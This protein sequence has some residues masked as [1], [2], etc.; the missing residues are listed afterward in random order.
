MHIM[1]CEACRE[2][3]IAKTNKSKFPYLR[4]SQKKQYGGSGTRDSESS[5]TSLLSTKGDLVREGL[6]VTGVEGKRKVTKVETNK[7][8]KDVLGK[9]ENQRSNGSS[10]ESVSTEIRRGEHDVPIGYDSG[11]DEKKSTVEIKRELSIGDRGHEESSEEFGDHIT[12]EEIDSM[13]Q[14]DIETE[15]ETENEK[16]IEKATNSGMGDNTAQKRERIGEEVPYNFKTPT[17]TSKTTEGTPGGTQGSLSRRKSL[18]I[19]LLTRLQEMQAAYDE[20]SIQNHNLT[21]ILEQERNKKLEVSEAK[22]EKKP[23]IDLRREKRVASEFEAF[24]KDYFKVILNLKSPRHEGDS[25]KNSMATP[26]K[27]KGNNNSAYSKNTDEDVLGLDLFSVNVTPKSNNGFKGRELDSLSSRRDK[28]NRR[29]TSPHTTTLLRF[30]DENGDVGLDVHEKTDWKHFEMMSMLIKATEMGRDLIEKVEKFDLALIDRGIETNDKA[31]ELQTLLLEKDVE[32]K[33]Y[34]RAAEQLE[35]MDEQ[36]YNLQS[37]NDALQAKVKLLE[38]TLKRTEV[39]V[40]KKS[41][42][43]VQA[44]EKVDALKATEAEL[45]KKY[46]NNQTAYERDIE[47]LRSEINTSSIQHSDKVREMAQEIQTLKLKLEQDQTKQ[48]HRKGRETGQSTRGFA[49]VS[50]TDISVLEKTQQHMEADNLQKETQEKLQKMTEVY[51]Q[52]KNYSS[53]LQRLLKVAQNRLEEIKVMHPELEVGVGLDA[54]GQ[55]IKQGGG[56]IEDEAN[57]MAGY[58]NIPNLRSPSLQ[59]DELVKAYRN[60]RILSQA[61]KKPSYGSSP[62]KSSRRRPSNNDRHSS[63]SESETGSSEDSDDRY[64]KSYKQKMQR[65]RRGQDSNN[66][67]FRTPLMGSS[68]DATFDRKEANS[69]RDD[70]QYTDGFS[71]L[72]SELQNAALP[73]KNENGEFK[74]SNSVGVQATDDRNDSDTQIDL[75]LE[76]QD[77]CLKDQEPELE[78]GVAK[79]NL[80][81]RSL[82]EHLDKATSD[83]C[84]QT[85]TTDFYTDA[86]KEVHVQVDKMEAG[87]NTTEVCT[88]TE[89]QPEN[90]EMSIQTEILIQLDELAVQTESLRDIGCLNEAHTQTDFVEFVN[91]MMQTETLSEIG[92]TTEVFIQT[93]SVTEMSESS[94]QTETLSE[95]GY[96]EDIFTQTDQPLEPKNMSM[97]TETLSEIGYTEDIFTQTEFITEISESS[98][99]TDQPLEPKSISIQTETLSEIGYIT[100]VFTQTDQ[101]IEPKSMSIQ[102]ETLSEIGY[103]EDTFTQTDQPLEPNNMSMQ[104]ESFTE[105]SESSIQTETLS[106]IGYTEDTFT[107]TDQPLEPKNMSIQTEFF[108]EISESSIQTETLSEIG[109]TAEIFTQTESVTEVED[110]GIQ[111]ESMNTKTEALDICTQT[112]NI[113]EMVQASVQTESSK[114]VE[115]TEVCTQTYD[116][117]VGEVHTQTI[118]LDF[119]NVCVQTEDTSGAEAAF[120][121]VIATKGVDMSNDNIRQ[122][123]QSNARAL[124]GSMDALLSERHELEKSK[125]TSTLISGLFGEFRG[126]RES[127]KYNTVSARRRVE[128]E[129]EI[130]AEAEAETCYYSDMDELQVLRKTSRS[131]GL[132]PA[133]YHKRPS[134]KDVHKSLRRVGAIGTAD[135]SLHDSASRSNSEDSA[136]TTSKHFDDMTFEDEH[137]ATILHSLA[138]TKYVTAPLKEYTHHK[139]PYPVPAESRV[140]HIPKSIKSKKSHKSATKNHAKSTVSENKSPQ[141]TPESEHEQNAHSEALARTLVFSRPGDPL[142]ALLF[143]KI[144]KHVIEAI[145]YTMIGSYLL[146]LSKSKI[147]QGSLDSISDKYVYYFW[148]HPYTK[149]LNWSKQPPNSTA[150]ETS[151]FINALFKLDSQQSP[152]KQ[153]NIKH[154]RV[155]A[156]NPSINDPYDFTNLS[157]YV[158]S[159]KKYIRI[160]ARSHAEHYNW[161]LALK[162]LLPKRAISGKFSHT[163]VE[164]TIKKEPSALTSVSGVRSF[165]EGHETSL[166]ASRSTN[167]LRSVASTQTHNPSNKRSAGLRA[168]L[169]SLVH[170]KSNDFTAS[171][172]AYTTSENNLNNPVSSFTQTMSSP[173]YSPDFSLGS[174]RGIIDEADIDQSNALSSRAFSQTRGSEVSLRSKKGGVVNKLNNAI[175]PFFMKKNKGESTG[176]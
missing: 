10:L 59:D 6:N 96:T 31:D 36:M 27:M 110:N 18:N 168:S 154:F 22:V 76:H 142:D 148:I 82:G 74:K 91:E 155:L 8:Q 105:I 3:L 166:L 115:I 133:P 95:I 63:A 56:M 146:K 73:S 122:T 80:N 152:A 90:K 45:T 101:P 170:N 176:I 124:V 172:S 9:N 23:R 85:I 52:E 58:E 1:R 174:E 32:S 136:I 119:S 165:G 57:S 64:I 60:G 69:L 123:E 138:T 39:E 161:V 151:N 34:K 141:N 40:A 160:K 70:Y 171:A 62:F 104:T 102:T 149:M 93:E 137:G 12:E 94:I 112:E 53:N 84:T 127:L 113:L 153:L 44:N 150:P 120:G 116:V 20:K 4:Q 145:S 13:L 43:L 139:K 79:R 49:N 25:M 157:I 54:V 109:C 167:P 147:I 26:T 16:Q 38:A 77:E 55:A 100:E 99:Q 117:M 11:E 67:K 86:D 162:Y 173:L 29:M 83:S 48:G 72:A 132:L 134:Q 28:I 42:M 68:D 98:I 126:R 114:K 30:E 128:I 17:K 156:D 103:T 5:K 130:E 71:S 66:Y 35:L 106:E 78:S 144:S 33:R 24:R 2:K 88:Q 37:E 51:Q 65:L 163:S 75:N 143:T 7:S 159:D 107:Q 15:I 121:G 125:L 87:R 158:Y 131:S 169:L 111:T 89:L 14:T 47:N 21:S 61:K 92:Y 118:P 46:K 41:N 50:V 140:V 129:A 97:Q 19:E 108:T 175:L 164:T 135:L 81:M